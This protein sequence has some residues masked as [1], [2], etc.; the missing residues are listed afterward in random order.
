ML[1]SQVKGNTN[2]ITISETKLDVKFRVDQFVFEGFSK[3]LRVGQNKN[4]GW[5]SFCLL[6]HISKTYFYR[7]DKH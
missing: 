1:A 5:I 7:K 6:R 2:V 3:S 4:E